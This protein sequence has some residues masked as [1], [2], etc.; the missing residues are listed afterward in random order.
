MNY[1][2]VTL[3]LQPDIPGHNRNIHGEKPT[4]VR[5]PLTGMLGLF[6]VVR[7]EV[8]LNESAR[9]QNTL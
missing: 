5:P 9:S 1:L 6:V 2:L 4:K 8:E 7:R 3:L